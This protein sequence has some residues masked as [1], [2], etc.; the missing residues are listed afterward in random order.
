MND[1]IFTG[2]NSNGYGYASIKFRGK[3]TKLSRISYIMAKG[4]IP[5]GLVIDHTCH[6]EAAR[7]GDCAGG[8]TCSHRACVNPTHLEAIT[9]SEN[10]RRGMH[11]IDNKTTCNRGHNY[12]DPQNIMVR[13]SGKRECAQC[14]RER[15]AM[16]YLK[17]RAV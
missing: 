12:A 2:H 15:A 17:S 7:R 10:V 3:N 16:N 14:N 9:Q 13:A 4:E 6:N 11:C 1:C 5:E 8:V